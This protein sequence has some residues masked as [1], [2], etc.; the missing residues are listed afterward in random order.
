MVSA[1]RGASTLNSVSRK[2]SGV[3]RVSKPG[4]VF[5]RRLRN[6]PAITLILLLSCRSA[7]LHQS[8]LALPMLL[9]VTHRSPQLLLGWWIRNEC[10]RLAAR[11][12]QYVDVANDAGD[13]QRRH[14]GLFGSEKF[15][16]PSQLQIHFRDV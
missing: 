16:R 6:S 5:S 3:G 2:R 11:D 4:S 8:V 15:A 14:S 13:S 7:H 10:L 12:F 9:D 1:S